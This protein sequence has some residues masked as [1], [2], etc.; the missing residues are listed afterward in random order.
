MPTEK[1]RFRKKNAAEWQYAAK[2]LR[3]VVAV[4]TQR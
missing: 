4:V 2:H 3:K 1:R